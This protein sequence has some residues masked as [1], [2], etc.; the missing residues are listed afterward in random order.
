MEDLLSTSG[1]EVTPRWRGL[2]LVLE[3]ATMNFA[4]FWHLKTNLFILHPQEDT[5]DSSRNQSK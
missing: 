1:A 5:E 2:G 3:A 4:V